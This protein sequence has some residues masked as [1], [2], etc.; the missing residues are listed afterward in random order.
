MKSSLVYIYCLEPN[1]QGNFIFECNQVLDPL[2]AMV[3]GSPLE[4]ARHLAQ[5]YSR[6]RQEAETHVKICFFITSLLL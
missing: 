5:R 1:L 6:M 4:D 2:R 3:A